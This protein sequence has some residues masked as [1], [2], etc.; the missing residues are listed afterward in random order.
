[1]KSILESVKTKNNSVELIQALDDLIKSSYAKTFSMDKLKDLP[2]AFSDKSNVA[3]ELKEAKDL[4]LNAN[5][6]DL[7]LY[8]E[9]DASFI[10]KLY[11]WFSKNDFKNFLL[12]INVDP[13]IC[14]GLLISFNGKYVDLSVKAKVCEYAQK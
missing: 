9:P 11:S 10:S 8:M 5:I 4:L 14:G 2:I 6:L 12:N 13:K 3:E 1:M 7:T